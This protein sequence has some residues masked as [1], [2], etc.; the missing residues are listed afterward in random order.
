[1]IA[2]RSGTQKSGFAL[3]YTAQLGIHHGLK[4]L[5]FSADMSRFTASARVASMVLGVPTEEIEVR[6]AKGGWERQEC[7][8]ALK[9]VPITFAFDDLGWPTVDKQIKAWA[10]IWNQYPDIVVFDNVMDFEGAEADYQIQMG[11][12]SSAT[13]FARDIGCTTVMLHHASDKSWDAKTAP[14]DPPSRQD[15]KNGLGEKPEQVWGVA[16]NPDTHEYHI[17]CLKQRMGPCDPTGRRFS[18]I[19][20]EPSLTRFHAK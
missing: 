10:E 5:Y 16:I 13:A 9:S 19:R 6:M 8:E 20:A 14:Y 15:I 11:V 3:W 4:T 18:T 12:M 2:G 7:I 1:M 17:A